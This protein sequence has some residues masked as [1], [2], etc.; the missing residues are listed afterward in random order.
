[1]RK[2]K[3]NTL[4]LL[5]LF[6]VTAF[7]FSVRASPYQPKSETKSDWQIVKELAE[8]YGKPIKLV[9]EI[10]TPE[11]KLWRIIERRKGKPYLLVTKV[12]SYGNGTK[13]GWY[14]TDE[15]YTYIIG[16]NKRVKIGKRVVSY[17][18]WNP[19]TNYEDDILYV[20]DNKQYR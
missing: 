11:K 6:L 7:S 8:D 18:I 17:I 2:R 15:G 19:E 10:K 5:T 4:L 13:H 16:Y 14:T 1:M 9:D 20:V 3:L 12:V